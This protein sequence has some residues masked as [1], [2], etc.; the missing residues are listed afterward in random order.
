[1]EG[2]GT[3]VHD[4]CKWGDSWSYSWSCVTKQR[5]IRAKRGVCHWVGHMDNELGVGYFVCT[6]QQLF[7]KTNKNR[8]YLSTVVSSGVAG[9]CYRVHPVLVCLS[10]M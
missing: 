2:T 1:M 3:E 5:K 7:G 4:I 8:D 9:Y 10:P 6:K